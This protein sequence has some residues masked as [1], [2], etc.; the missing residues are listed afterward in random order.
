MQPCLSLAAKHI[1][2]A[3]PRTAWLVNVN[4]AWLCKGPKKAQSCDGARG[5][6]IAERGK[7]MV[8]PCALSLCASNGI[9][10]A[11]HTGI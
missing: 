6:A 5:P 2:P 9:K 1:P 8:V 10:R 3:R 11:C 4:D 7:G